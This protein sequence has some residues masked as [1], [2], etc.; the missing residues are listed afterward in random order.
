VPRR[1]D[2]QSADA[3]QLRS[4]LAAAGDRYTAAR[5]S[6]RE[7]RG[8]I[9]DLLR[10]ANAAGVPMAECARLA[11]I[12]RVMAYDLLAEPLKPSA[13]TKRPFGLKAGDDS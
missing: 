12:S 3:D 7:A 11:Q 4:D 1:T 5:E 6:L 13:S 8:E 2:Q 9:G 10:K